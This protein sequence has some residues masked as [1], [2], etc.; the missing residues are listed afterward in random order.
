MTK[1]GIPLSKASSMMVIPSPVFPE[2]V[3]DDDPVGGE[4]GAVV[5]DRIAVGTLSDEEPAH[6]G[7][8]SPE[9]MSRLIAGA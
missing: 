4:V 6:L 2:P 5:E 1:H 8:H 7:V 3:I 9:Y